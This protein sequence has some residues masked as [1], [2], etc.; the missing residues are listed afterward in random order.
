MGLYQRS[1]VSALTLRRADPPRQKFRSGI[2]KQDSQTRKRE[3]LG[4]IGTYRRVDGLKILKPLFS[5]LQL[6]SNRQRRGVSIPLHCPS[7]ETANSGRKRP[8]HVGQP[9]RNMNL[10]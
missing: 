3:A 9:H 7:S 1:A 4:R 10:A 6:Q 5:E 2:Y 8:L